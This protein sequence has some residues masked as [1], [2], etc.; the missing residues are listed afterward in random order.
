AAAE[1]AG[2]RTLVRRYLE[3]FGPASV[4]DVAQ[5]ALVQR[6][7]ARTALLSLADETVRLVGPDG[8]ELFDVPDRPRPAADTPAPARLMAM[9][10]STLLAYADRSRIIPPAYRPLVIRR[11]GDVLPTLLVDGYV[12]GVWRPAAGGGIE[13]TA[14][15][16]LPDEVWGQLADEARSLTALLADRDPQVYHRYAHWWPKLPPLPPAHLLI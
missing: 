1:A 10:D 16:E 8:V 3:G 13:A 7:R 11:N 12:A 15:H 6:A 5:F 2:L 14:F 4:A 9:W